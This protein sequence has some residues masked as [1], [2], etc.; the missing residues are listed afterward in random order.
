MIH[1]TEAPISREEQ[2]DSQ[3]RGH[4]AAREEQSDSQYRGH[5]AAFQNAKNS[6]RYLRSSKNHPDINQRFSDEHQVWYSRPK[7]TDSVLNLNTGDRV[8]TKDGGGLYYNYSGAFPQYLKWPL[9]SITN[10]CNIISN[11]RLEYDTNFSFLDNNK[12]SIA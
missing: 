5:H 7:W 12:K 8:K 9:D 1:N 6:G 10:D 3:Y 2:S 4:H 11:K